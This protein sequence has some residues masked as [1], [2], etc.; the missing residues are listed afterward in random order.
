MF[1]IKIDRALEQTTVRT[2]NSK[3]PTATTL[4]SSTSSPN[5]LFFDSKESNQVKISN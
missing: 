5:V 4:A 2:P 3:R 1:R